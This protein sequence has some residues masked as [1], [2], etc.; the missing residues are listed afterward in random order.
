MSKKVPN[1]TSTEWAKINRRMQATLHRKES[2]SRSHAE[3]IEKLKAR[4]KATE[5]VRD[6][7]HDL[8]YSEA[9]KRALGNFWWGVASFVFGGAFMALYF[10]FPWC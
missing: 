3:E 2:H 6:S 7:Y 8:Y 4:I 1:I 5:E 9:N 10:T